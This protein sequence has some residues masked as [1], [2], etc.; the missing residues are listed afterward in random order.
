MSLQ[1]TS[2][3]LALLVVAFISFRG[4]ES[5]KARI[6]DSFEYSAINCRAHSASLTDF[7]G[8]G[9]GTTSNTKAFKDAIDHLSQFSS[10]GGSQLF[11]PAGKWLTGS[12]S[13]TSHFTLYLHKDAVLLASQVCMVTPT[14]RRRSA[15]FF[16]FLKTFLARL[17][18]C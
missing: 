13:L 7:G 8:V 3:V 1:V 6:L 12:F 2:V 18:F 5:R 17:L 15:N 14:H 9:D 16:F 10:D 11:V 4:A